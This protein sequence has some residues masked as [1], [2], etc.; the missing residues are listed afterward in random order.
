MFRSRIGWLVV[1]GAVAALGCGESSGDDPEPLDMGSI[2]GALP[3]AMLTERSLQT[4]E[5]VEGSAS[6]MIG[7]EVSFKVRLTYDDGSE[8]WGTDRAEWTSDN[9]EVATVALGKVSAVAPGVALITARFEGVSDSFEITVEPAQ[10]TDIEVRGH[11][12]LL[13]EH[14]TFTAEAHLSDGSSMDV[15]D[16]V[17]WTTSNERIIALGDGGEGDVLAGGPVQIGAT[18]EGVEGTY[19][20]TVQCIYPPYVDQV[21]LGGRLP[22]VNW[23][24]GF[25]RYGEQVGFSAQDFHCFDEFREKSVLFVMIGAGWCPACTVRAQQLNR[26][27]DRIEAAGGEVLHIT[28]QTANFEPASSSYSNEHM[29]SLIGDGLSFRVGDME[30][31]IEDDHVP[32]FFINLPLVTAFPTVFAVRKSDMVIIAE[33]GESRY[34]LP[35]ENIALDPMAD[36]S[37]PGPPVTIDHCGEGDEEDSEPENNFFT[38]PTR[39]GAGTYTGGICD[40]EPDFYLVDVEGPWRL[41][42]QF[43]HA[44]GDLGVYAFDPREAAPLADNHGNVIGSDG[45]TDLETFTHSGRTVVQV[46]GFFGQS[47]PYELTITPL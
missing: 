40:A 41:D 10:I 39:I 46:Y 8:E 13:N 4:L 9:E 11:G 27:A 30:T 32:D 6:L 17:A 20:T 21:R 43:E 26:L 44:V 38:T 22:P 36:W 45:E 35:Y 34:L 37:D 42:L 33:Q 24:E 12:V 15:T 31:R 3:D 1:L 14:A 18:F 25:N 19:E 5:I 2:D 16:Q 28:A 29:T 7:A 47:A 23:P